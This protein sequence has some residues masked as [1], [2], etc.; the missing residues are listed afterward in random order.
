MTTRIDQR[1]TALAKANRVRAERAETK[2]KL[3]A[4]RLS[5]LDLLTDV[6]D[7]MATATVVEVLTWMPRVGRVKARKFCQRA[8]VSPSLSLERLG[9]RSRAALISAISGV[10][11]SPNGST[12]TAVSETTSAA[13]SPL[14]STG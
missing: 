7:Y 13:S 3:A 2:R 1:M 12:R 14:V 4:G 9:G 8:Q 11:S 5:L 10:S 6:P